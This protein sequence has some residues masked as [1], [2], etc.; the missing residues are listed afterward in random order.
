MDELRKKITDE[1]MK[2]WTTKEFPEGFDKKT[3][4]NDWRRF[5]ED[6]LIHP[7]LDMR[8]A[9]TVYRMNHKDENSV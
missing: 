7:D 9:L 8:E 3:T 5:L 1:W 4:Y 6:W 2:C